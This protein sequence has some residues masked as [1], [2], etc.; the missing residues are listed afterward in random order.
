MT[1]YEELKDV[2]EMRKG[3]SNVALSDI[4][5][6]RRPP[7]LSD[8]FAL[9][10]QNVERAQSFK[11]LEPELPLIQT[12]QEIPVRRWDNVFNTILRFL[13]HICLISIFETLF[14]FH[15]VS[16][17]EDNGIINTMGSFSDSL[18][19]SCQNISNENRSFI[20][21]YFGPYVNLFNITQNANIM[22]NIRI[23]NNNKL[24]VLSWIYVGAI[25]SAFVMFFTISKILK[26]KIH[27]L[28]LVLENVGFV[29]ML[30]CYEIMFFSKIIMPYSP[31]SS[32]EILRNTVYS[33]E[34]KCG[35][36]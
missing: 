15:Y 9:S 1:S 4:H 29:F 12:E 13:F 8:S 14:F 26:I 24:Y 25:S 22:Y 31:I 16:T 27:L 19:D 36:F 21:Q 30:A 6:L 34:N 2:R 18:I 11:F 28:G 23:I 33:L 20:N 35:L 3:S 7:S 10:I 17:L 5:H 32:E